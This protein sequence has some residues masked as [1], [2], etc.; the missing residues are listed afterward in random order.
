MSGSQLSG[1]ILRVRFVACY[2]RGTP[3]STF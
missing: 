1:T 2:R 3:S